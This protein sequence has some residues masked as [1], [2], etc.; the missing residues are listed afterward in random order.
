M[1]TTKSVFL[2]TAT[3]TLAIFKHI[4]AK[5]KK[6]NVQ[7]KYRFNSVDA[8]RVDALGIN[9]YEL[10]SKVQENCHFSKLDNFTSFSMENL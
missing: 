10:I 1:S 2:M 9:K 4:E 8:A 5:T 7:Y 6:H 3:M